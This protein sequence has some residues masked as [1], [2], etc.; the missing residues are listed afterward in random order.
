MDFWFFEGFEKWIPNDIVFRL[1]REKMKRSLSEL[2]NWLLLVDLVKM[3]K[4]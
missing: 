2:K 4:D 3:N 1:F